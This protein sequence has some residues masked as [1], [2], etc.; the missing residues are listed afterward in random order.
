[1]LL[2]SHAY[3]CA[4]AC[5]AVS[6]D[7]GPYASADSAM[8]VALSRCVFLQLLAHENGTICTCRERT[9]HLASP[10]APCSA[11]AQQPRPLGPR[12]MRWLPSLKSASWPAPRPGRSM[13][14]HVEACGACGSARSRPGP[15]GRGPALTGAQ[16]SWAA[17]RPGRSMRNMMKRRARKRQKLVRPTAAP[18]SR[19]S[20]SSQGR[21]DTVP[22]GSS[23]ARARQGRVRD[24][25]R[26]GCGPD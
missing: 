14:E 1:V 8:F 16:G 23:C 5:V 15:S 10:D 3:T 17:A 13:R 6:A 4:V 18:S 9:M 11:A 2:W 21:Y 22:S 20:P 24:G 19:S 12:Y 25:Q 26:H 7:V